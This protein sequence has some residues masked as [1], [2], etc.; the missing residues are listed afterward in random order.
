[1]KKNNVFSFKKKK[2]VVVGGNGLLGKNISKIF[3]EHGA[4]IYNIEIKKNTKNK[5]HFKT[6]YI[7]SKKTNNQVVDF[8]NILKKINKFDVFI[9]CSYPKNLTWSQNTFRRKNYDNF[10]VNVEMHLNTFCFFSMLVAE[11]M[12]KKKI[13]GSIINFGSIYGIV[14]QDKS[15]YKNTKMLENT[16]YGAIK[17]G[18]INFTKLL[19]TNYIKYGI[20][21][22]S[23]SPGG[24]YE[25]KMS[26]KF[27][28]N[29]SRRV[30]I[31]RLA[32]TEE[33]SY[34]VL[35]LASEASSYITGV[36]LLVDGGWTSI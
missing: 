29:Y 1:M 7:D 4:Q 11:H 34:P 15:I 16:A 12:R 22:N 25:K 14:S 10:S 35:F 2:V 18:I 21:S 27:I 30:P 19:S 33:I 3:F 17:G 6:F 24:V 9:N 8:E 26:K 20:R 31:G 36:N 5:Y 23:I 13:K 32:K 28:L